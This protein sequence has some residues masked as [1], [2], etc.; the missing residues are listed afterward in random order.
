MFGSQGGVEREQGLIQILTEL[1]GFQSQGSKVSPTVCTRK[2]RNLGL[3]LT[4]LQYSTSLLSVCHMGSS[5]STRSLV[6]S[7]DVYC[8]VFAHSLMFAFCRFW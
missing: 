2:L 6:L 5:Y 4:Q 7:V 8:D 1:D 3:G